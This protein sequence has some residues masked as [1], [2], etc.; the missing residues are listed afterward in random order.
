ML[1]NVNNFKFLCPPTKII[2]VKYTSS[3]FEHAQDVAPLPFRDFTPH[4]IPFEFG[5]DSIFGTGKIGAHFAFE[6]KSLAL[7]TSKLGLLEGTRMWNKD[8]HFEHGVS[9]NDVETRM[10]LNRVHDHLCINVKFLL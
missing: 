10:I 9:V 5:K 1:E 3:Y 2:E 7:S 6:R 4:A 8:I